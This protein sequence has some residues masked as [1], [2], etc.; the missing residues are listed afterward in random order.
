MK[1][2][3]LELAI[4]ICALLISTLAA[5]ASW[6][7]ARVLQAQTHVL[8]EQLGAQ[9]WPYVSVSSGLSNNSTMQINVTNDG[10]GPAV[11]GSV[12][13]TVDGTPKS[14]FIE[15]LHAILGPHLLARAGKGAHMAFSIDTSQRG[16]VIR[17]GARGFGYSFTSSRFAPDLIKAT[18]RLRIRICYCAILPGKC[19]ISDTGLAQA[20]TTVPDCPEVARD[21][22]HESAYDEILSRTF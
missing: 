11:L 9:V 7:Q 13:A 20:P 21:L 3:R 19:W 2:L 1:A 8:E 5:G 6:W 10:L 22:L 16:A 4:A 15:I 17:P 14:S 18:P 12:V